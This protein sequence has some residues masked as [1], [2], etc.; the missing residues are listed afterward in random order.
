MAT[1][2]DGVDEHAPG[3]EPAGP[4]HRSLVSTRYLVVVGATT[5]LVLA[6]ASYVWSIAKAVGFVD[7]LLAGAAEEDEALVKLFATVDVVLIGTVMLIIEAGACDQTAPQPIPCTPENE[8][9]LLF[10]IFFHAPVC[11]MGCPLMMGCTFLW[12]V[13]SKRRRRRR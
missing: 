3:D 13:A 2:D 1:E 7:S 12:L 9:S 6:A 10:T 5:S 4:L 11:G 8:V